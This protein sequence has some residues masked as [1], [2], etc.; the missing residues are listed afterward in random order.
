MIMKIN[1]KIRFDSSY[2]KF[3]KIFNNNYILYLEFKQDDKSMEKI[4]EILSKKVGVPVKD[5]HFSIIGKNN[6]WV[7]DLNA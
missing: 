1:V 4:K 3:E 5:I 7:F 6:E 2:S